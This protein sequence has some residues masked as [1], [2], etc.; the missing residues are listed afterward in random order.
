MK[1]SYIQA[2][3]QAVANKMR[4]DK[5]III[6]GQDVRHW[7]GSGGAFKDFYKE[8]GDR[9]IDTPISE[10]ATTNIAI[11][12]AMC[13]LRPIVE[14]TFF[15]FILHAMDPVINQAAKIKF[16]SA[17]QFKVP[18]VL[19]AVIHSGRG[20]GAT[21]CQSLE[22]LFVQIPGL[23]VV[24]PSN[25]NDAMALMKSALEEEDP[26][27]FIEHRLLYSLEEDVSDKKIKIGKAEVKKEGDKIT[28]I[29]YGR[30]VHLALEAAK[31]GIEVIDLRSLQP[32]DIETIGKSVEKTGRVIFLEEGYG[33]IGAEV[34]AQIC[35]RFYKYLKLPI[36]RIYTKR[37]PH[38]FSK[39]LEEKI[40]PNKEL[41]IK[42]INSM[43]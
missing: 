8:F 22:S 16:I 40:I 15:D 11:G 23:K 28:L 14:F 33:Y 36:K 12:A 10:A 39:E 2:I 31:D 41:L 6:I 7:G 5:G 24:Y 18:I 27:I 43:L 3:R 20:Y 17:N 21:H 32:L 29:T 19:R 4:E 1:L 35:E 42:E 37:I 13:G 38:P 9:I 25:P 30:M 26:V 34:S